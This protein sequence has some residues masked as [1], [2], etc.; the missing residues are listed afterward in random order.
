ME[1]VVGAQ[2]RGD[3]IGD[4]TSHATSHCCNLSAGVST[5]PLFGRYSP[6][7]VVEGGRGRGGPLKILMCIDEYTYIY[8]CIYV[9]INTH[10][11]T[12]F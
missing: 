1:S 3:V 9:Q 7:T 8:T 5:G 6:L 2:G 10:K 4:A 12:Y 11:Y